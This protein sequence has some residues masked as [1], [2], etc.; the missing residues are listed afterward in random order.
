MELKKAG[1]TCLKTFDKATHNSAVFNQVLNKIIKG[2]IS[3]NISTDTVLHYHEEF[4][5]FKKEL[6]K[7]FRLVLDVKAAIKTSNKNFNEIEDEAMKSK[8]ERV[9]LFYK[10]ALPIIKGY[11]DYCEDRSYLDFDGLI[12]Y[13]IK[14]FKEF[15][16]IKDRYQQRFKYVMVDEFQDVN[17]QQVEFLKYL[18]NDN[19]QLFC[20]GDDWQ[21][22][23]GFRGSEIEYIVNF[24][25]HFN[26][27]EIITLN[28]NYRSTDHIV[29]ASNEVIKKNQFQVSKDISAVKKG[30]PKIEVHY[31]EVEGDDESFIWSKIEQ[32]LEDG[33]HPEEILILYRRSAMKQKVQDALEKSGVRVQFKTIHGS[34]G[35]E[36]QVVFILGL[37][38]VHGGF[39]DPWMQDK[40]Y[41]VIKKTEYNTL[42]EEE[43]RLFYV[44]LTR[45][46]THLYLMSQ[47]G[48][49]SEF[50]KD[51]PKDLLLIN[52]NE[53]SGVEYKIE[54]CK[55]CNSK[56]E[57]HFKFCPICG[58]DIN[59]NVTQEDK[60]NISLNYIKDKVNEIPLFHHG[61]LDTHIYEARLKHRRAY[62]PWS[63]EED[64]LLRGCCIQFPTEELS[65]LFGRS[66]GGIKSRIKELKIN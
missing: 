54:L 17:N 52:E 16:T 31:A 20:V 14:L 55:S 2:R 5:G 18:V 56:I 35:L 25:A 26:E 29:K 47:K 33:I 3:N 44:A 37:N 38:S 60:L 57:E 66:Q 48:S 36:A 62:E 19:S 28:L 53:I 13:S 34:K 32:H 59:V 1:I 51:I 10:V 22:I 65:E 4:A 6:N 24:K 41:Y 50:I 61:W 58:Q 49:V 23:Y 63:L 39:P 15:P 12:D 30:G 45:A 11:N 64:E 7:F 42:L 9:R 46:K 8:H 43:R 21:S 27:P 40:I